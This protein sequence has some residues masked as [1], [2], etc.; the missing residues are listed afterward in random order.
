VRVRSYTIPLPRLDKDWREY[1][2]WDNGK[3]YFKKY[4]DNGKLKTKIHFKNGKLKGLRLL[5]LKN[6]TLLK[7]KNMV[8]FKTLK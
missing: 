3:T 1:E 6:A 2:Y 4:W 8:L 7:P 5:P